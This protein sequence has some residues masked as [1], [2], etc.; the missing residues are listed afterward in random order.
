MV[1]G[2]PESQSEKH[3]TSSSCPS[4]MSVNM[5]VLSFFLYTNQA[6]IFT[7]LTWNVIRND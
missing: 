2:I 6:K 5:A 1:R 3:Q 7:S 4:I